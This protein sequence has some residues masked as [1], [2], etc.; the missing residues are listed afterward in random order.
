ME[1]SQQLISRW[2]YQFLYNHLSHA[3]FSWITPFFYFRKGHIQRIACLRQ[4]QKLVIK[5]LPTLNAA[6]QLMRKAIVV[7]QGHAKF[8]PKRSFTT[9]AKNGAENCV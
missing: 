6:E 9:T 2:K 8:G 7:A 5:S 1:H 4:K 3:V